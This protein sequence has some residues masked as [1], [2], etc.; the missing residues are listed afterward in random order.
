L[1]ITAIIFFIFFFPLL[2]GAPYAPSNYGD[3]IEGI[4]LAKIK[5]G[6]KAVD[7]G[8]GDGTAVLMMAEKGAGV[9]GYEISPL[10][11]YWSRLKAKQA[12]P[13]VRKRVKFLKQSF[14]DIDLSTYDVLFVYQLP[15]VMKR[16]KTKMENE[17]KPG[18]RV[19]SVGFKF[20]GWE[21]A[22]TNGRVYVYE[23]K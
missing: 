2:W 22:E 18:A 15:H 4:K 7:L 3:L 5:P 16:L 14:W 1:L 11:V 10:L 9:T 23:N 20:E 17:L 21:P 13:E 12:K 8:S 6:E 19:I